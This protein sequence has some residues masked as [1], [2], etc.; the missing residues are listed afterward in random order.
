L[1]AIVAACGDAVGGVVQTL[2]VGKCPEYRKD[3]TSCSHEAA[4]PVPSR[5]SRSWLNAL[6]FGGALD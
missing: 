3:V 1:V 4:P 6:V 2:R 5:Y